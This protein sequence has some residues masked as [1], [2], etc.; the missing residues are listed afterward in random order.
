MGIIHC[1]QLPN[2]P[3]KS[4]HVNFSN[5]AIMENFQRRSQGTAQK[6]LVGV[7][8]GSRVDKVPLRV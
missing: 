7:T 2:N 4:S 3:S 6:T 5:D 8:N 1:E